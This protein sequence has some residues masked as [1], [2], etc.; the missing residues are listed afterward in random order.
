MIHKTQP[1]TFDTVREIALTMPDVE[2]STSYGTPAMKVHGRLLTRLKEDGESI[3]VPCSFVDR[4]F[5]VQAE[6]EVFFFTDHYRDYELIL[7]R[8]AT[9]GREQLQDRLERAYQ[10]A[11]KQGPVKTR[12]SKPRRPKAR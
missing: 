3:V 10:I 11:R 7:I 6:P 1:L 5:L 12:A 8:L 9:V 4:D 2:E